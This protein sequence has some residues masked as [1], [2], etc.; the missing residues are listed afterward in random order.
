MSN[1]E[2][3]FFNL[4]LV[5]H[6]VVVMKELKKKIETVIAER[7]AEYGFK[8]KREGRIVR[9]V[10]KNVMD[11]IMCGYSHPSKGW[12]GYNFIIGTLY[13]NI[14]DILV[15]FDKHFNNS[16]F[17]YWKECK[18]MAGKNIGYLT[19]EYKFIQWNFSK[20]ED[21]EIFNSRIDEIIACIKTYAFP[22][23]EKM[24]VDSCFIE[25]LDTDAF[26]A[27]GYELIPM[28]YHA[29][30]EDEYA[31]KHMEESIKRFERR[32]TSEEL[33]DY[34]SRYYGHWDE[35]IPNDYRNLHCA[36]KFVEQFKAFLEDKSKTSK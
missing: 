15:E 27:I 29:I 21:E 2:K 3:H 20:E 18:F 22:Y 1:H 28:Y 9:I 30:G 10:N 4:H 33:E 5:C 36:L 31:L 8:K 24:S 23:Y 25:E 13:K 32:L 6:N 34:Y 17:S 26:W 14:D 11:S 7:L 12:L 35:L 16:P 19:P